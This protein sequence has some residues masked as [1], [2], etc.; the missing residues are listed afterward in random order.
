MSRTS[1]AAEYYVAGRRVPAHLQRHGHRRRLDERGLVHRDGRHAVPHRLRRP[2]LHHGLDR[3]LLPGGVSA[4]A[5]PAQVRAVHDSRLPRCALRGQPA[6]LHRHRRRDPVLV[7]LRGGADL[8]RGPDHHAPVRPGVR[9]RD[10]RRPGRH[11]GVLVPR[12]HA[13]RHL[14]AGGAVHH[15]DHRLPG[16]AGLAVGQADRRADPAR[17]STA[18]SSRRW[19]RRATSCAR[20]PRSSRSSRSSR[21]APTSSTPS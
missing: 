17:R 14:D 9:G 19:P 12:R 1:D 10:L 16:A 18:T 20:I 2:G 7:H 13:R 15:P 6:A 3:R 8:R 21:S 4:G 5:V 11:P